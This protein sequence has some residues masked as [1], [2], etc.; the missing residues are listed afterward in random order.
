MQALY[1]RGQFLLRR[2][3]SLLFRATARWRSYEQTEVSGPTNAPAHHYQ[4]PLPSSAP[5]PE[6]SLI[7]PPVGTSGSLVVMLAEG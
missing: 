6:R 5:L 2:R 7:G 4:P 3:G 1:H